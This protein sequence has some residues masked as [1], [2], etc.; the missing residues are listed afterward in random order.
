MTNGENQ[1]EL[2]ELLSAHADNCLT[3][4][5]H[6][7]LVALLHASPDAQDV[8]IEHA[9][10]EAILKF[11][12]R[13]DSFASEM[14]PHSK[15]AAGT[16]PD[17]DG[18]PLDTIGTKSPRHLGKGPGEGNASSPVLVSSPVLGWLHSMLHVGNES[19]IASALMWLV[20]VVAC[21]GVALTLF[22]CISLILH[23]PGPKPVG[24]APEVAGTKELGATQGVPDDGQIAR[25]DDA[26]PR[27]SS[28]IPP[29]TSVTVARL[30]HSAEAR[31]VIGS[32]S[33]HLGD[34][35]ES[36]RKLVM[37]SGLAEI[38]FQS[39]VRVVLEGPATMEIGSRTS[40][41]LQ[42]GKLTVQVE[43]PDAR[44]F[45]VYAPGMKYTDLGTEFGV[46]VAK[47]GTQEMH[48][49]RGI[50]KAEETAVLP[51]PVLERG[52]GG[53]PLI[54]TARQAIRV[55]GLGKPIERIAG[56]ERRFV[57]ALPGPEPFPLFSTGAGLDRSKPDP[58][59]QIVAISGDPQFQPRPAVVIAKHPGSYAWDARD[60]GQWI[61]LD[62]GQS[63]QPNGCLW[64]LRTTFDLSGF[65][66][67]T[68]RIEGRFAVDNWVTAIRLNGR[69]LPVVDRGEYGKMH[70]I[71][72][73]EG[74]VS[75]KN[76]LEMVVKNDYCP[77]DKIN[78]MGIC[79]QW[80]GFARRSLKT[81][82]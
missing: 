79:V 1:A 44:G 30:I 48:V 61:S 46:F 5:E 11:E 45:A 28:S 15:R 52:N 31:W 2:M 14:L 51:S 56:D 63:T 78:A 80:K 82:N 7:R 54:V 41:R 50:V 47:D 8:L 22:F 71:K 81:D 10:L 17:M 76:I 39:G 55:L 4:T 27:P 49:F 42:R 33:P 72:I 43:D 13:G 19:P 20:L 62:A 36:G 24:A 70:A 73:E 3:E 35:L 75:G 60:E 53:S 21:S 68:A 23:G 77:P 74:F 26:I 12:A 16:R 9:F 37:L 40:A 59:W 29:S 64:T 57:R 25:V 6:E 32:H 69:G 34:D 65:D 18:G 67:D 38:M 58:H 66:P